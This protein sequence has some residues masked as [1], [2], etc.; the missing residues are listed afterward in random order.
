MKP[1]LFYYSYKGTSHLLNPIDASGSQ[2]KAWSALLDYQVDMGLLSEG[3]PA[4]V[5]LT[6][7]KGKLEA[8]SIQIV[9]GH[10]L[11]VLAGDP[12]REVFR[13][14][15]AEV[16]GDTEGTTL[17]I[18]ALPLDQAL[19]VDHPDL[20]DMLA[21][22][23]FTI[24]KDAVAEI[25][26]W[27]HVIR[28][29]DRQNAGDN[30]GCFDGTQKFKDGVAPLDANYALAGL[31]WHD[32]PIYRVQPAAKLK[33]PLALDEDPADVGDDTFKLDIYIGKV[34]DPD[35]QNNTPTDIW[36]W[37]LIKSST[38]YYKNLKKWDD[39]SANCANSK[40]EVSLPWMYSGAPYFAVIQNGS[41]KLQLPSTPSDCGTQGRAVIY[42]SN[43]GSPNNGHGTA[44]S[45]FMYGWDRPKEQALQFSQYYDPDSDKTKIVL[46]QDGATAD[47]LYIHA[48]YYIITEEGPLRLLQRLLYSVGYWPLMRTYYP[49]IYGAGKPAELTVRVPLG[50]VPG[51]TAMDSIAKL[52][53]L[54]GWIWMP[55]GYD[56]LGLVA[57][58]PGNAGCPVFYDM[59]KLQTISLSADDLMERSIVSKSR[60]DPATMFIFQQKGLGKVQMPLLYEDIDADTWTKDMPLFGQV[61]MATDNMGALTAAISRWVELDADG[62]TLTVKGHR[63]DLLGQYIELP[64]GA[65]FHV[66]AVHLNKE[67][68]TTVDISPPAVNIR[69]AI[70]DLT[71]NFG[72]VEPEGGEVSLSGWTSV[73][74][75]LG[76][77]ASSNYVDYVKLKRWSIEG[78]EIYKDGVRFQKLASITLADGS[79]VAYYL[80]TFQAAVP[81]RWEPS[82]EGRAVYLDRI[83]D[84][85]HYPALNGDDTIFFN[86]ELVSILVHLDNDAKYTINLP[87]RP[88]LWWKRKFN[89][90]LALYYA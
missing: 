17:E 74:E 21:V 6:L 70:Q 86:L 60:P 11:K 85:Q 9:K 20:V 5:K 83:E 43:I 87:F 51:G 50:A 57:G 62:G 73:N 7:V 66:K 71:F 78:S 90:T 41:H 19:K 75:D 3:Q 36:P 26:G 10:L 84:I 22:S 72:D 40:I 55:A 76:D 53:K 65:A 29:A 28:L 46:K 80:L 61:K 59:S 38:Y 15:V 24:G 23:S 18:T 58:S 1:P 27:A 88:K 67:M 33:I 44:T 77:S 37:K 30:P 52:A 34:E 4:Q 48:Y 79:K 14:I 16:L 32:G 12:Q 47:T 89:I 64:G 56:P 54:Q 82:A 39:D 35:L 81:F 31:I 42:S 69:Q 45:G 63:P 68:T 2:Y 13:G 25:D 8:Q 49:D